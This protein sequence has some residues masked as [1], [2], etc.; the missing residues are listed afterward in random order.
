MAQ[1]AMRAFVSGMKPARVTLVG[2]GWL[3]DLAP[4]LNLGPVACS[5]EMPEGA[6][7]VVLFPNSIRVA[8]LAWRAG[9]PRRI[10][11]RGQWRRVLLT[12]APKPRHDMMREHHRDYFLDLAEQ[13]G[14]STARRGVSLSC[15][16]GAVAEG[17]ALLHRRG[18][19]AARTVVIAPGAQFGGA[20]RY[21]ADGYRAVASELAAQGWQLLILG[22]ESE[23]EIGAQ[24]IPPSATAW[25]SC[26][27]TSLA[28]ALQLIAASRLLLCNDSGL[29]HVAAGIGRPVVA[30]FG[31]TD[32]ARTAPD[33]PAVRLLY[34]PA[35][36]SPCLQRECTVAGHPCMVAVTPE[37]VL[38]AVLASLESEPV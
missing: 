19:D 37:E 25:N 8:W 6:N 18:L 20:K 28:Q 11:F 12:H 27:K 35:P 34:R 2:R 21:P 36:C 14:F 32:P 22:T 10:G 38:E 30:I 9:I 3:G 17:T 23:R 33:G 24:V 31:A 1:P 15:P 29:M 5:A 26:G 4:W 13:C 16:E 7:T